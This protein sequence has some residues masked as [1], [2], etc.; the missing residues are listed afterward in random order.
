M[1]SDAGGGVGGEEG[2]SIRSQRVLVIC[3]TSSPPQNSFERLNSGCE[4]KTCKCIKKM[5]PTHFPNTVNIP[6]SISYD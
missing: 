1:V 3:R 6:S 4:F 5:T 2:R